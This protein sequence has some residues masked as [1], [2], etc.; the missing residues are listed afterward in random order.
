MELNPLDAMETV[1]VRWTPRMLRLTIAR[2]ER[3]NS[4]SAGLL[5][6]LSAALDE[7][8]RRPDCRMVVIEGSGGLFCTGMD[9]QEAAGSS[10]SAA[11][12]VQIDSFMALLKRFTLSPKVVVA[13]VDGKVIAGG[14]GIAAACDLVVATPRSEFSLSEALWG[15]LPCCVVPFLIRRVGFQKA[16]A[17]T[18]TTR[19]YCAQ[20]AAAMSL[21][22]E[23]SDNLEE[24]LRK[25][26]LRLGL[27]QDETIHD[28]KHYFRKMWI[29]TPEME[30]AAVEEISRLTALPRVKENI[31]NYVN[32]GTFPWEKR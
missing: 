12:T 22:D 15:M 14:V 21:V 7:A 1:E 23:L 2:P 11:E 6:D 13:C 30:C 25:L 20:E 32:H 29:M 28:L 4:I 19:V 5:R 18:L 31:H 10:A 16:Y 9:F 3:R 17:M 8:E 27:L 24:T 26:Q